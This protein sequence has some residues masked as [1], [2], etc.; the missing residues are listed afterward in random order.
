MHFNAD[1]Y[2]WELERERTGAVHPW[3]D[4][5]ERAFYENPKNCEGT[6]G[7]A[8]LLAGKIRTRN[9]RIIIRML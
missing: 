5:A 2:C 6:V 9:N 3:Y 4:D 1:P 8:T 7:R